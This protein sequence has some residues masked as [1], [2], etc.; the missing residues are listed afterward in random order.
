MGVIKLAC[1]RAPGEVDNSQFETSTPSKSGTGTTYLP[2]QRCSFP[3]KAKLSQSAKDEW[4]APS[5]S[6]L[7]IY[8]FRID[9]VL[10]RLNWKWLWEARCEPLIAYY[11]KKKLA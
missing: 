10:L 3:G 4:A 11:K 9:R 5:G 6:G 8:S 2:I 7:Q 1:K